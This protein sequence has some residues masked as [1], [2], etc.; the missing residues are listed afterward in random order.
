MVTEDELNE[1][2]IPE[3]F[4]D[5]STVEEL[6]DVIEYERRE[7]VKLFDFIDTAWGVIANA[8]GGSFQNATPEWRG[9]AERWR[10]NY[11]ILLDKY[12]TRFDSAVEL[13]E[14]PNA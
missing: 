14:E 1:R 12:A 8:H 7:N 6:I 2:V 10:D 11:H 13:T 5:M 3:E 4:Q 9:A